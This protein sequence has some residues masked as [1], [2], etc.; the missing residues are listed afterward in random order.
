MNYDT[1]NKIDEY[2]RTEIEPHFSHQFGI[3]SFD[4]YLKR[5]SFLPSGKWLKDYNRV[6]FNRNIFVVDPARFAKKYEKYCVTHNSPL[7]PENGL[8][9]V[10]YQLSPT[11][12]LEVSYFVWLEHDVVNSYASV[13]A[14]YHDEKEYLHLVNDL[15]KMKR[16]GNTDDK[17][18][19][20]GLGGM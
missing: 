19:P 8:Q 5:F 20:I 7:K 13:I 6:L 14:C 1:L 18:K 9:L 11:L 16:E 12:H 4:E 10:I 3:T 17:R 2:W 15:H